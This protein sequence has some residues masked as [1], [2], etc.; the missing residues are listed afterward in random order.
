MARCVLLVI[1][2]GLVFVTALESPAQAEGY[3]LPETLTKRP[4]HISIARLQIIHK[5][6]HTAAGKSPEVKER[7]QTTGLDFSDI[8]AV[9]KGR[10]TAR[11]FK[12]NPALTGDELTDV[13]KNIAPEKASWILCAML[14]HSRSSIRLKA[15]NLLGDLSQ[16]DSNVA[17][18]LIA[19]IK[20]NNYPLGDIASGETQ[21]AYRQA[22]W[23]SLHKIVGIELK[24]PKNTPAVLDASVFKELD[25]LMIN[26][27][28]IQYQ[29]KLVH[30]KV[31]AK[32]APSILSL[33]TGRVDAP[34]PDIPDDAARIDWYKQIGL[35]LICKSRKTDKGAI[36]FIE[37]LDITTAPY[38]PAKNNTPGQV[39]GVA[40]S[41]IPKLLK[42]A[43]PSSEVPQDAFVF[44]TADGIAGVLQVTQADKH[45]LTL[46]YIIANNN[47][48]SIRTALMSKPRKPT[49]EREPEQIAKT[50]PGLKTT[51]TFKNFNLMLQKNGFVVTP[52]QFKRVFAAYIPNNHHSGGA[53]PPFITTDSA[54]DAYHTLLE[55]GVQKLELQ[56]AVRLKIFS[57]R[58]LAQAMKFAA[59]GQTDFD[60]I[61]Q[62]ASIAL[63]IQDPKH[64]ASITQAD[65]QLL[66]ALKQAQGTVRGPVGFDIASAAFRPNGFYASNQKLSD[67]F[68]ARQWYAMIVFPASDQAAT[69]L[70][71]HLSMLINS[72]AELRGL[73]SRLSAP[74]DALLSKAE[75]GDVTSYVAAAVK[76]A[77]P[78]P[79]PAKIAGAIKALQKHLQTVLS[80]PKINDQLIT[81]A[82]FANEIK[83]FRLLPP[84]R[85]TSSVCFQET[86][87]PGT[88]FPS[89]LNFLVACK[90]MSS[91]AAI[92]AL[93]QQAGVK[94]AAKIR[95]TDPGK[96]PDSLHGQAMQLIA[97]LQKPPPAAAPK[98]LK[99]QAWS[100]KQLWTQLGAWA[101]Q[102]HTWT[103]HTK[104]NYGL[105]GGPGRGDT[106]MVSPYPEFFETLGK[107]TL[108]T[109]KV[110]NDNNMINPGDIKP[111]S[112]NI[113]VHLEAWDYH[114]SWPDTKL[115]N[116]Q[117]AKYASIDDMKKRMADFREECFNNHQELLGV[118]K[119]PGRSEIIKHI[120]ELA[121]RCLKTG[122][123]SD[124]DIKLLNA[125]ANPN[126]EAAKRMNKFAEI[127]DQLANIARKQLTGKPL[128]P[129]E[130]HLIKQYGPILGRLLHDDD[131]YISPENNAPII[132]TSFVQPI[133]GKT[134]YAAL[135]R[136]HALYVLGKLN[137]QTTLMRGA[138]LGFREFTHSS[139][140]PLNDEEW[141]TI[142]R[143]GRSVPQPPEFT[144][145]FFARPSQ[146]EVIQMLENG[147]IYSGINNVTGAAISK[148]MIAMLPTASKDDRSTL[149]WSLRGRCTENDA[150][151]LLKLLKMYSETKP[152]Q[153][154]H[155]T[156]NMMHLLANAPC[157]AIAA[158]LKQ[159]LTTENPDMAHASAYILA[160]QPHLIDSAALVAEYDTLPTTRRALYCYLLSRPQQIG[161]PALAIILKAMQDRDACLRWQGAAALGRINIKT[162]DVIKALTQRTNDSNMYVA[163]AALESLIK[164]DASPDAET[165]I[166]MLKQFKH[167][168]LPIERTIFHKKTLNI[169][170]TGRINALMRGQY[171][172]LPSLTQPDYVIIDKL[173]QLNHKQAVP[174]I[175]ELMIQR[176]LSTDSIGFRALEGL[177]RQNYP[178]H[179][180]ALATNDKA[181]GQLRANALTQLY[182]YDHPMKLIRKLIPLLADKTT[183]VRN[184]Y[185]NRLMTLSDAAVIAIG[186]LALDGSPK[187]FDWSGKYS[188]D[189]KKLR[190]KV[191]KWAKT[192]RQSAD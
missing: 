25:E 7:S 55:A 58:L 137:G 130:N 120:R 8:L 153:Y 101:Q 125:F 179:L 189:F 165:L 181:P 162:P 183:I 133:A 190:V 29:Q 24:P 10:V 177:D 48:K 160:K 87:P 12:N 100:D 85:L 141:R 134:L 50:K 2:L 84:R 146:D 99:T 150:A 93:Q 52:E 135:G 71:I 44:R 170:E 64:A 20:R 149:T 129:T 113:R 36:A 116:Q 128:H 118:S 42:N 54:W 117:Y 97:T 21:L 107:L 59:D 180:V 163:G 19:A 75:D 67:Y 114:L 152:K 61:V 122:L 18:G 49:P 171:S 94:Q 47:S 98:A 14:N 112:R 173:I 158:E 178:E 78:N 166:K 148:K 121:S 81:I 34:V 111:V 53:L 184:D 105:F 65:K 156:S 17:A 4:A 32:D 88:G 69:S 131:S 26:T 23:A 110:L 174:I 63:A 60:K 73:W 143:A 37:G 91:P 102:R 172:N 56:Q 132:S 96:L 62:Y 167:A 66:A 138:V 192:V 161:K 176:E 79:T 175:L 16:R 27:L 164:L 92:R 127:C 147:K 76:I 187:V 126:K 39:L 144:K 5:A 82:D 86:T 80:G 43:K 68:V 103:L 72:D 140:Q 40:L 89:A 157:K 15:A 77:G 106:G 109:A 136:P 115:T 95:D 45:G 3:F 155:P 11:R 1:A 70:A 151:P 30:L 74:Y 41:Q 83:G 154:D 145:S 104:Q 6:I 33:T 31:L 139:S 168:Y 119:R 169:P 185:D 90:Q 142:V 46:K 57:Q 188:A 22:L 123:A 13:T 191:R 182:G 124:S 38:K 9:S 108:R 51:R 186:Q 28:G 159:M 35:D